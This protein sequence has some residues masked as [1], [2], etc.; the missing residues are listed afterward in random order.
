MTIG[1]DLSCSLG[2]QRTV[3][4][5]QIHFIRGLQKGWGLKIYVLNNLDLLES[6]ILTSITRRSLLM[7][8]RLFSQI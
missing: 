8:N 6:G 7:Q 4:L 1:D 3:D 5:I 2:V